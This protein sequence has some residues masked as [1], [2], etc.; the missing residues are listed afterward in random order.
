MKALTASVLLLGTLA[1]QAEL[2]IPRSVF[3]MDK[4]SAAKAEAAEA[5]KPLIFVYTDPGSS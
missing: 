3:R 1:V 2:E 4:L 5:S